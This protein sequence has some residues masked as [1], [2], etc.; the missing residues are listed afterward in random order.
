MAEET[1][2]YVDKSYLERQ[3]NLYT[4]ELIKY[5]DKKIKSRIPVSFGV[6]IDGGFP[7]LYFSID[8]KNEWKEVATSVS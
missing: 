1:Y 7:K 2:K 5:I 3:F 6:D 4:E 8:G